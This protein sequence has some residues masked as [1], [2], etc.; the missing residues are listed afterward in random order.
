MGDISETFGRVCQVCDTLARRDI[1]TCVECFSK[2]VRP[3]EDGCCPNC[4]DPRHPAKQRFMYCWTCKNNVDNGHYH[5]DGVLSCGYYI[6][7]DG[8][9]GFTLHTYKGSGMK[10]RTW[11]GFPLAALTYSYLHNHLNCLGEVYGEI[12]AVVPIPGHAEKLLY[13]YDE[14]PIIR[15]LNDTRTSGRQSIG[16]ERGFDLKRFQVDAS[17]LPTNILLFDDVLTRGG[18][19]HSAAYALKMAGVEKLVLFTVGKRLGLTSDLLSVVYEPFSIDR[20]PLCSL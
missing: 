19:A 10:E 16:G 3:L 14:I 6:D 4:L 1:T 2:Y 7:K 20:C 5:L 18:T 8:D 9:F 17:E 15:C 13:F 11:M 12:D